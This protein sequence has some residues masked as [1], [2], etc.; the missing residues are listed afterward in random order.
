MSGFLYKQFRQNR[1]I[2]LICAIIPVLMAYPMLGLSYIGEEDVFAVEA[3]FRG[4][5]EGS[6][7]RTAFLIFGYVISGMILSISYSGDELK[8]W[9]FFCAA[10]PKGVKGLV[11]SKYAMLFI[12]SLFTMVFIAACDAGVRA[13]CFHI[14]GNKMTSVNMILAAAF[15]IQLIFIAVELPFTLRF[16]T[17]AGNVVKVTVLF[18]ALFAGIVYLLFG[19]IP[20][21]FEA[22][23]EELAM[24]VERI[25][26][27]DIPSWIIPTV[28]AVS[29]ISFAVS[30]AVSERGILKGTDSYDK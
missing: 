27:G 7:M 9:V 2:I 15:F 19:P 10:T 13:V 21:S 25:A 30:C 12:S 22:F 26:N 6:V 3:F 4:I 17:K 18:G 24:F 11:R 28:A 8:K 16:G 20:G 29:V 5:S 1:I 14:T 23:A